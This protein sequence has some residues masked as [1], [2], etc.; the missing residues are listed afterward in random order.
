MG[1]V[2]KV[3]S[4]FAAALA[5]GS[6]YRDALGREYVPCPPSRKREGSPHRNGYWTSPGR[7]A[8]MISRARR[9]YERDVVKALRKMGG[10]ARGV[11]TS[12]TPVRES[13]EHA[14]DRGFG[15]HENARDVAAR[16]AGVQS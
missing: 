9:G 8:R 6:P 5:V 4:A 11:A 16:I 1:V 13:F 2:R 14:V 3:L 15:R 7:S 10:W 12:T